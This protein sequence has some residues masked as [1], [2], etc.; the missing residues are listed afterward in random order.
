MVDF[1]QK[2]ILLFVATWLALFFYVKAHAQVVEQLPWQHDEIIIN[3]PMGEVLEVV[4][5]CKYYHKLFPYLKLSRVL[6]V[7]QCYVENKIL[8]DRFWM[9]LRTD[10]ATSQDKKTVWLTTSMVEGNLELF[11][12]RIKIIQIE[13]KK[14]KITFDMRADIG[15]PSI[16][17]SM[18]QDAV[19]KVLRKSLVNLQVR[20]LLGKY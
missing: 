3:S 7:N 5:D 11:E 16:T 1:K 14:T 6:S 12:T 19:K 20:L 2:L 18:V 15:L 9:H 8:G 17:D 10:R 4:L 13:E